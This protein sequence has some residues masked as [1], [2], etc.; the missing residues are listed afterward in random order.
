[1]IEA[2]ISLRPVYMS[3]VFWPQFVVRTPGS[4]LQVESGPRRLLCS[5]AISLV[6]PHPPVAHKPSPLLL[7]PHPNTPHLCITSKEDWKNSLCTH[8]QIE[9][10]W[11]KEQK[12]GGW[13][14][15]FTFIRKCILVL[16]HSWIWVHP[17]FAMHM[18]CNVSLDAEL[19]QVDYLFN[20]FSHKF[21]L[22]PAKIN[23]LH[24]WSLWEGE[25]AILF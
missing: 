3:C 20:S 24:T 1:M 11:D 25:H 6:T 21:C 12:R 13:Q 2:H 7:N 5:D 14:N 4:S 15:I 16:I 9:N 19:L 17:H 10:V 8:T 18:W 23:W 22:A